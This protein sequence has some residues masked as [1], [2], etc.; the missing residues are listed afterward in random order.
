[1]QKVVGIGIILGTLGTAA[2]ILFLLNRR[3]EAD[4]ERPRLP[5]HS[6]TNNRWSRHQDSLTRERQTGGLEQLGHGGVTEEQP[7]MVQGQTKSEHGLR[8]QPQQDGNDR[9]VHETDDVWLELLAAD[10]PARRNRCLRPPCGEVRPRS[11]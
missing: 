10:L 3:A 4:E 5:Y 7:S 11:Q 9:V 8:L 6:E 2:C 1:M